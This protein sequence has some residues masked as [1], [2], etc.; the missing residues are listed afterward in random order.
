MRINKFIAH[1][2]GLSR[3]EADNAIASGRVC[4]NGAHAAMGA[5]VEQTDSV[6]LD[7][8]LIG[9]Q[10]DYTYLALNKPVGYLCSRRSQ[11]GI[12]T[13]Y[14]L[15]PPQYRLLKA[16]G[17]L[18]KDS[19][20]L[21]LLTDDG[22]FAHRMTHPSFRKVKIYEVTLD[23]PLEPLHQQMISDH[24]VTLEDGVSQF[25]VAKTERSNDTEKESEELRESQR[26][27]LTTSFLDTSM[28]S[29]QRGRGE[30]QRA[31]NGVVER[32]DGGE[33]ECPENEGNGKGVNSYQV[34]MHEGRNR[35]IRR[36]FAALGY[37]VTRL[38]RS[39]FG[40][41]SLDNLQDGH[42][43]PVSK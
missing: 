2:T 35:Q 29:Q 23:T 28:T 7:N 37:T 15:L 1:A 8:K 33:G 20:G 16:V 36:T 12:P 42:Y 14:S 31:P 34:T 21:L 39:A 40:P 10:T 25:L 9:E 18:D 38:H 41:Y 43:K 26:V 22:D 6:T 27:N 30:M 13:I 11:G 5:Q 19:S 4:V 32:K 3:R 24:G 17:R